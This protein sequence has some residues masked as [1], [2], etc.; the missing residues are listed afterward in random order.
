MTGDSGLRTWAKESVAPVLASESA[1]QFIT[2]KFNMTGDP[3]DA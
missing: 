2:G 3:L 1:M